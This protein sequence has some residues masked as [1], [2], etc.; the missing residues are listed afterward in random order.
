MVNDYSGST[1]TYELLQGLGNRC[2]LGTASLFYS[3]L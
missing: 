3:Y 1:T 2:G